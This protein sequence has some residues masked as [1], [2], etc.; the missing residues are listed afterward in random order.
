MTSFADIADRLSEQEIELP[1]WAF[2]N[3]GTRF[4]VFPQAGV[5]R[6]PFEKFEDAWV[7]RAPLGWSITDPEPVARTC[8]ALLSDWLPATT[9]EIV[10]VDGGYHAIGA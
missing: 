9:G 8:V 3:S 6:D 4:R 10:H 1:S 5:P 2:G 7:A